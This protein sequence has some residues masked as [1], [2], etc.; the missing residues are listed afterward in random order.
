MSQTNIQR[1]L[2]L[3]QPYT[4]H[5]NYGLDVPNCVHSVLRKNSPVLLSAPHAV[6][7][8]RNSKL[9]DKRSDVRTGGLCDLLG[10]LLGFSSISA[11]SFVSEWHSW[12]KR[13]DDFKKILESAVSRQQCVI[14]LHGMNN[15]HDADIIIGLGRRPSQ[16]VKRAARDLRSLLS[17]LR[18]DIND[19]FSAKSSYTVTSY[20]QSL[21]GDGLQI[22]IAARL[23]NPESEPEQADTFLN[24]MLLSLRSL[25]HTSG[26]KMK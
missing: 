22:E 1:W 10:E 5:H 6:H 4:L 25:Q 18:V 23:R 3:N 21:G 12:D 19:R 14:D 15:N 8:Y 7:H 26:C 13:S 17:P 24:A 20:V 16:R 9:Q 2:N 11:A